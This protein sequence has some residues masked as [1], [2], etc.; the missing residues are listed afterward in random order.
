[1]DC[2]ISK[3]LRLV[4]NLFFFQCREFDCSVDKLNP[5]ILLL[6]TNFCNTNKK[7]KK[8]KSYNITFLIIQRT[9]NFNMN[10]LYYKQY[11]I[12]NQTFQKLF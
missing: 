9:S 12:E 2:L 1:M 5:P 3:L 8:K 10:T 6:E 4:K 11:Y 7:K